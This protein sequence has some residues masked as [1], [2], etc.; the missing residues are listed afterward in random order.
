MEV[1]YDTIRYDDDDNPPSLLFRL[2]AVALKNQQGGVEKANGDDGK[3]SGASDRIPEGELLLQVS[4]PPTLK[5]R[6]DFSKLGTSLGMQSAGIW[7]ESLTTSAPRCTDRRVIG[8]NLLTPEDEVGQC[9]GGEHVDGAAA[10]AAAS[11]LQLL[12]SITGDEP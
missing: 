11:C 2:S 3:P 9:S 10:A 5:T 6:T 12:C 4:P 8:G 1:A 7:V